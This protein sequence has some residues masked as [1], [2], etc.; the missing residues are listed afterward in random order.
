MLVLVIAT[1]LVMA[2]L[3]IIDRTL[4]RGIVD[5]ELCAFRGACDEVLAAYRP[6]GLEV[7]LSIGLDYLFMPLYAATLAAAV[8][9][10]AAR[11][12]P[13]ARRAAGLIAWG[14]TCAAGF[15]AV[16]NA[17]LY[18]MVDAGAATAG[19]IA[20]GAA[21]IKFALVA[22]AIVALPVIALRPKPAG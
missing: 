11:R 4:P 7:G 17:A 9:F 13:R 22:L 6:A 14:A 19:W 1:A 3:A 2:A 12:S 15:D 20:S 8:V 18:H 21:A 16:E 10:V 5:F